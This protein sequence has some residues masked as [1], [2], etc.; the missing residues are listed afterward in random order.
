[1]PAPFTADQLREI[2]AALLNRGGDY[3]EIF[4]ERR[5]AHALGMDDGRMEDVLASETFGA[6][7]RLM[8]GETTRFADLIAPGFDELLEAAHTL[9]APGTGGQAESPPCH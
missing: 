8:D 4:V 5:R 6:S 1:M 9:A 7:L 2:L 3:G